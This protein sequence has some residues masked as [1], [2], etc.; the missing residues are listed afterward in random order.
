MDI[1]NLLD[2]HER[3]VRAPASLT[4]GGVSGLRF[5]GLWVAEARDG[6]LDWVEIP[7]LRL[8]TRGVHL[9]TEC[10][11]DLRGAAAL[12][13]LDDVVRSPA[14]A[15][16]PWPLV[17]FAHHRVVD[18]RDA[19]QDYVDIAAPPDAAPHEY[20]WHLECAFTRAL[21][22]LFG[23]R[24]TP[25]TLPMA[26]IYGTT[27]EPAVLALERLPEA[28]LWSAVLAIDVLPTGARALSLALEALASAP[29]LPL[30]EPSAEVRNVHRH[31]ASTA[32]GQ[33]RDRLGSTAPTPTWL[34]VLRDRVKTA[35]D[36]SVDDAIDP[37]APEK[38][39][40]FI[41]ANDDRGVI[42]AILMGATV[43]EDTLR[44][45]FEQRAWD[46]A[47]AMIDDS[48]ATPSAAIAAVF[49]GAP[50]AIV[51][52]LLENTRLTDAERTVLMSAAT[53][54]GRADVVA[55][56]RALEENARVTRAPISGVV[57]E[58]AVP[59]DYTLNEKLTAAGMT[60]LSDATVYLPKVG[61]SFYI[62]TNDAF[63]SSHGNRAPGFVFDRSTPPQLLYPNTLG[64]AYVKIV[65]AHD[66]TWFILFDNYVIR[67]F[68][69]RDVDEIFDDGSVR[70]VTGTLQRRD[71]L[72]GNIPE[73][74]R[75]SYARTNVKLPSV[76]AAAD[77]GTDMGVGEHTIE[78]GD[79][80]Y[81]VSVFSEGK[82]TR[83]EMDIVTTITSKTKESYD[84]VFDT[85]FAAHLETALGIHYD[86][87]TLR[88]SGTDTTLGEIYL[89]I[90]DPGD[91]YTSRLYVRKVK[92]FDEVQNNGLCTPFLTEAMRY[93]IKLARGHV[94]K[95]GRIEIASKHPVAAYKCFTKAFKNIGYKLESAIP[96]VNPGTSKQFNKMWNGQY[97]WHQK[98][99]FE[100][101][102]AEARVTK[103]IMLS[104]VAAYDVRTP[105][106]AAALTVNEFIASQLGE[107]ANMTDE[108]LI[109]AVRTRIRD[110]T[111]NPV[112]MPVLEAWTREPP[113]PADMVRVLDDERTP[114]DT[115]PLVH[116]ALATLRSDGR[117]RAWQLDRHAVND[118][119][120]VAAGAGALEFTTY[121]VDA[122]G[123]V[124]TSENDRAVRLALKN[125]HT[126]V[127][128]M[129]Y[130][131]YASYTITVDD[132]LA[133][134]RT[135]N[136]P[137]LALMFEAAS[138]Y[139]A[140][141]DVVK[142]GDTLRQAL[143][144]AVFEQS[145]TDVF[146]FVFRTLPEPM[147]T[148]RP[149]EDRGNGV[150]KARDGADGEFHERVA[151]L[152]L[153]KS[154]Y[155]IERV[156]TAM[157]LKPQDIP[158][159]VGKVRFLVILFDTED[160]KLKYSFLRKL[161]EGSGITFGIIPLSA[162]MMDKE[163]TDR[164][165]WLLEQ[166]RPTDSADWKVVISH[167]VKIKAVNLLK[168]Y[169]TQQ[170]INNM[171]V[172]S[173]IK[174]SAV[175]L[176][177]EV[178]PLMTKLDEVTVFRYILT[179]VDSNALYDMV[180]M[181]W[182]RWSGAS[183]RRKILDDVIGKNSI[184]WQAA[185][186]ATDR[187]LLL[188]QSGKQKMSFAGAGDIVVFTVDENDGTF[189]LPVLQQLLAQGALVT[190][191]SFDFIWAKV[192][193]TQKDVDKYIKAL[194]EAVPPNDVMTTVNG[195]RLVNDLVAD[196][197]RSNFSNAFTLIITMAIDF[198][199]SKNEGFVEDDVI[200]LS[201]Y[202][203]TKGS[204][205]IHEKVRTLLRHIISTDLQPTTN[206]LEHMVAVGEV[207]FVSL[208]TSLGVPVTEAAITPS[209]FDEDFDVEHSDEFET[210]PNDYGSRPSTAVLLRLLL[211]RYEGPVAAVEQL[212]L[213]TRYY[214]QLDAIVSTYLANARLGSVK[215]TRP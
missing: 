8:P 160:L 197:V 110:T 49:A 172:E 113:T 202:F 150:F 11:A 188:L 107:H 208:F 105:F 205:T 87:Y 192:Q 128:R 16:K 141:F 116:F 51:V 97:E 25:H 106:I 99:D 145:S 177:K 151:R 52:R 199:L 122:G 1:N 59:P 206:M 85:A 153:N 94:P 159:F 26:R 117:S 36:V 207:E 126:N 55:A 22:A 90:D 152:F 101:R 10:G 196:L 27:T 92:I 23:V 195:H 28:W 83:D 175:A 63:T 67:F 29:A 115:A 213:Y 89:V 140:Y 50:V 183:Q 179:R 112:L 104:G 212:A 100:R 194:L 146:E 119:F 68:T 178:L 203:F 163:R 155:F 129:L 6:A 91:E 80:L 210:K 114:A 147:R 102:D 65:E 79:E 201:S 124:L 133:A 95:R 32:L 125:G 42:G 71:D 171:I 215:R 69:F 86:A 3:D 9:C 15:S 14:T 75:C 131:R 70:V 190:R 12:H 166:H 108:Q 161:Y 209:I 44:Y 189:S 98:L 47:A 4:P 182:A 39:L 66:S 111:A 144:A 204:P 45:A 109:V 77:L 103:T 170:V 127:V 24:A 167:L 118:A 40:A 162:F 174:Q 73:N 169:A 142:R 139:P 186:Y 34:R 72:P 184:G 17:A 81:D 200:K 181:F 84:V 120:A 57:L 185:G 173:I 165:T 136:T 132:V 62:G 31:W 54:M 143:D 168:A 156:Y 5:F 61:E 13:T 187:Y 137:L 41:R 88:R 18:E 96:S 214:P 64:H 78:R 19:S 180:K 198:F 35:L 82:R 211:R 191:A 93:S 193:K 21:Y 2:R 53:E 121:L 138:T 135:E 154:F 48:L 164:L 148:L 30:V 123:A 33:L 74:V 37:R 130:A 58:A 43:T 56:V 134:I 38:L 157:Q 149:L 7:R 76:H 20:M 176:L 158:L 46:A 60:E